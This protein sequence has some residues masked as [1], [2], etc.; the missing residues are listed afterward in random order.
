[1]RRFTGIAAKVASMQLAITVPLGPV[2]AQDTPGANPSAAAPASA[3]AWNAEGRLEDSDRQDDSRRFDEHRL[4]LEAGRRYRISAESDDFDTMLRLFRPGESES[5]AENDDFGGSLNSRITYTAQEGG[6]YVIRIQSFSPDGRGAYR[7]RTE[8]LPP[9][10]PPLNVPPSGTGTLR[11]QMWDG[12]L[13]ATDPDRDGKHFDDYP[14]R[15]VQGE[16]RII[17]IESDAIDPII[18]VMRADER[19]GEPLEMDDDAGVRFNALLAFQAEDGGNYIVRVTSFGDQSRGAY[20]L[21]I[22]DPVTPP[23]PLAPAETEASTD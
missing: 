23:L 11:W 16:T 9:I 4:R 1:M 13:S 14:V 20:R 6:E 2:M 3:S 7:L 22:S 10:P 21:R 8:A 17:S 18:W 5:V 19:E 15:M 12:E